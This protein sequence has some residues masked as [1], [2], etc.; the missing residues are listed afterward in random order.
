MTSSLVFVSHA[1]SGDLGIFS[2]ADDGTLREEQRIVL[3]GTLMPMALSLDGRHLYV[4]RRSE[5]MAVITLLVDR[6]KRHIRLVTETPLPASMAYISIDHTG[7]VLLAASYQGN[8]LSVSPIDVNGIPGQ[9]SQLVPTGPHAH[10]V[11]TS[12]C[13]RFALATCLGAD[14]VLQFCWDELNQQ[15][16][17]NSPAYWQASAGA[18]PRH[19][20]FHPNTARVYVLNELDATIDVLEF[21]TVHG[22]LSHQQTVP[23]MSGPSLETPWAADIHITPDGLFLYSCERNTSTIAQFAVDQ[24]T[25]H[26]SLVEH[27]HTEKQPRGFA[28]S[29]CGTQLLVAGQAS[30]HLSRYHINAQTGALTFEQRLS[31][32]L[33]PNWITILT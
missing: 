25:G 29:S 4:A 12:P 22:T 7:S 26:L 32:G 5:P 20:R 27:I 31:T 6:D 11:I 2:M 10:A 13:N 24:L 3:G 30:H 33:N 16:Q 15:L 9:A 23:T 18:G 8:L 28:I 1:D 19:L 21:D 17:A 14:Q